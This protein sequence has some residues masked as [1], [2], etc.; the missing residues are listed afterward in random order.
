METNKTMRKG[1]GLSAK[2][3]VGICL[4]VFSILS[5]ILCCVPSF[6]NIGAFFQGVFGVLA[7]PLFLLLTLVGIALIM[8]LSYTLNKKYAFYLTVSIICVLGLFHTIF[9]TK[10][11]LYDNMT[12]YADMKRYLSYCYQMTNGIT[13]GGVV[14]GI[15]VFA[16]RG[17]IGLIGTYAFFSVFGTIFI[18]LTIDFLIHHK[19]DLAR[20]NKLTDASSLK[21]VDDTKGV[22]GRG[23]EELY[24]FSKKRETA[25]P[26]FEGWEE[27]PEEVKETPLF[28]ATDDKT[29]NLLEADQ[30]INFSFN[31]TGTDEPFINKPTEE[32]RNYARSVLF[33]GKAPQEEQESYT[34]PAQNQETSE[35]KSARDVLFGEKPQVPN[36]FDRSSEERDAWRRQYASK[37][38]AF[39]EETQNQQSVEPEEVPQNPFAETQN[40]DGSINTSWGTYRPTRSFNEPQNP[41]ANNEPIRGGNPLQTNEDSKNQVNE[42]FGSRNFGERNVERNVDRNFGR[43]PERNVDRNV[44]REFNRNV[45]RN[46]DRNENR[47]FDRNN[48]ND[49][50]A[51]NNE[52]DRNFASRPIPRE[53]TTLSNFN[54]LSQQ[55][56]EGSTEFNSRLSSAENRRENDDILANAT[57]LGGS[58]SFTSILEQNKKEEKEETPKTQE[59]P[60]V[61]KISFVNQLN[62]KYN[63][64]PTDILNL[65]KEEKIDYSQEYKEKTAIIESILSNFKIPAKVN[66]VVR[67]P[68]V[69]RYELAMPMGIPVSRVLSYEKDLSMGLA[70]KSGVRIEAPIPG[71]NAFGIEVENAKASMVGFR[72]LVESRE[73]QTFKHPL[74]V[75]IGKNISG[76]II[77]KDLGRMVHCLVAGSTGSGKSV[78]LHSLI[79]S[80]MYKLSPEQLRFIMI[81]PKRVEFSRYNRMPHLML[82]EVVTDCSKAVNALSWAV[83]EME[84]RYELL[85]LNECQKLEQFNECS[86]VKE[87][88]EKKLP[89]LVIVVDE[90]AELMGVAAKEAESR[91]QRITQLGRAAGIHMVVAT[92]RPSV[93]VVT[94]TIKNNLPTRIAFALASQVDSQTIINQAGAEKLLGQG[95]MLLSA[96]DSNAIVRL[97]AAY[98]SDDE[99]KKVLNYIKDNNVSVYDEEIQ[100]S[101]YAEPEKEEVSNDDDSKGGAPTEREMDEYMPQALKLVMKNGKASISMIQRRF[102]VGYARAARIIDQMETKG[103]IDSGLGNKPRDVKITVAEY[104]ELFGDFDAD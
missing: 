50:N 98:V 93:D 101:I 68:K 30:N 96:Q 86:A 56:P 19:K 23:E 24:T 95:D 35:P 13:V 78:F 75:A 44:D 64:P 43:V 70:S 4:L 61:E 22:F 17:L 59:K 2:K 48:F 7:Y 90:L 1:G 97:Q 62:T 52:S 57:T 33:G 14:L 45:E 42:P 29:E 72:E 79:V 8:D 102:S 47:T 10:Y 99:I 3:I 41:F 25:P 54:R 21:Q 104:N 66:N 92:Q 91:I 15:L 88:R 84:R 51:L 69:T 20:K 32:S 81:D 82:P 100:K 55:N 6:L 49:R 28:T 31:D 83:K 77:V 74:P 27:E 18:G 38:L 103:F 16:I 40:D 5:F 71:K 34:T 85:R 63:A 76:E 39:Q 9:T 80:L 11:A 89:Y 37:P 12:K 94:G 73:Y 67:G 36:I 65:V 87:G 53:R 26:V 46:I 60:K 58:A